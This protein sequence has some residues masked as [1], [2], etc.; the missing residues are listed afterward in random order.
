[1][2]D[3]DFSTCYQAMVHFRVF[4]LLLF[5]SLLLVSVWAQPNAYIVDSGAANVSVIDTITNTVIAS[6]PV[7]TLP[8][9]VA[10]SKAFPFAFVTIPEAATCR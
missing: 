4:L 8:F 10:V 3:S 1:M 6:I 5:S 2:L 7:G 9:G